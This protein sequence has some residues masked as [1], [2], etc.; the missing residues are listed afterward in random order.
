MQ[1]TWCIR[2]RVRDEVR[3]FIELSVG[4]LGHSPRA[5]APLD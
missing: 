4:V 5:A 1:F 2:I 3:A